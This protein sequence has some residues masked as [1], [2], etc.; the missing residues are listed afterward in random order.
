MCLD[1]VGTVEPMQVSNVVA[2]AIAAVAVLVTW[3]VVTLMLAGVGLGTRR[4]LLACVGRAECPTLCVA[5]IWTGVAALSAYLLVWS[6][7]AAIGPATWIAPLV[8]G[9]GGIALLVR[10]GVR[11]PRL[12]VMGIPL[13]ILVGLLAA[14]SLGSS[15]DYDGGLY[16]FGAIEYARHSAAIRGLGNLHFRLSAGVPHFLF[17]AFL[18]VRPWSDAGQHLAN[19]LLVSLLV[20]QIWT[21]IGPPRRAPH[22]L[23]SWRLALL[24]VPAIVIVVASGS[25]YFISSPGLDLP[26]FVFVIAAGISLAQ[27]FERSLDMRFVLGGVAALATGAAS[28]PQAV[29]ALVAAIGVVLFT[30]RRRQEPNLLSMAVGVAALPVVLAIGLAGRQTILSGYPLWP[31]GLLGVPVDWKVPGAVLARYREETAAWARSP[32]HTPEQVGSWGDWIGSWVTSTI[33]NR[34]V[35]AA[36]ALVLAAAILLVV[37]RTELDRARR[38]ERAGAAAVVIIPCVAALVVWFVAA[39][40]VRFAFGWI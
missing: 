12:G 34:T 19:G 30:A 40:D 5:D 15:H 23:M 2:T 21:V 10:G 1:H 31:S 11:R 20:F 24:A 16:H 25:T 27:A 26:L 8:V 17:V 37:Y 35:G 6:M 33:T 36:L 18:G 22:S 7:L 28:R 32:G 13:L 4:G 3:T 39:P 38:R 29:P 9:A 14:L